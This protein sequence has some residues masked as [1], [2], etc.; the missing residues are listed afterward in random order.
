[1]SCFSAMSERRPPPPPP[2]PRNRHRHRHRHRGSH[3]RLHRR[4]PH[5]RRHA[6]CSAMLARPRADCRLAA[7]RA[8]R[9]IHARRRDCL[10]HRRDC[11]A[12]AAAVGGLGAILAT[13]LGPIAALGTIAA[14]L[15]PIAPRRHDR[16]RDLQPDRLRDRQHPDDPAGASTCWPSRPRKS[17]RFRCAAL[18]IVVAEALRN[19]GV[20]VSHALA[21]RRIV[22]PV[23]SDVVVGCGD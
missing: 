15:G 14:T 22:L 8:G 9:H 6:A 4:M 10:H 3:R 18:Q 17:I 12:A 19:V 2:P 23:V 1:M 7:A 20:V 21:M 16:R 13:T 11:A 5:R